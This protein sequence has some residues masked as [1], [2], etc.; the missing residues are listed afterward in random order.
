[1]RRVL[2]SLVVAGVVIGAVVGCDAESGKPVA[3]SSA[4]APLWDPCSQIPDDA[5][6]AA[7]VD[8]ATGESGIGGVHQSGWE[9]CTW[10]GDEYHVT[11]YSTARTV[12]E[13]EQK[14]G[15]VD[16]RDVTIDGRT[17][18]EFRVEGA[19]MDLG[20]DVVFSAQQGVVGIGILNSPIL[21]PEDL[22]D[23]CTYLQRAGE[24][25]VPLFPN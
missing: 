18:R 6:R 2:S 13:F 1:M 12:A 22:D 11:V 7:Q 8:P 21:E 10:R 5:L 17:G 20:C 19:S 4:P 16:F 9:M 23:P 15:Q 25:L 24:V 14:P 3:T